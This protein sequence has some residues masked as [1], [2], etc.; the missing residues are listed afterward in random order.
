M[1]TSLTCRLRLITCW[2]AST[3]K[4]KSNI[5]LR[6]IRKQAMFKGACLWS[7]ANLDSGIDQEATTIECEGR[8]KKGKKGFSLFFAFFALFAS[9][10]AFFNSRPALLPAT[11]VRTDR[12][13]RRQA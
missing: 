7:N 2:A 1:Q 6:E 4:L 13:K 5:A 3:V 11:A 9:L 12:R 10:F 8:S